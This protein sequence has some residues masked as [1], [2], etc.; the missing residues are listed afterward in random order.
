MLNLPPLLYQGETEQAQSLLSLWN[1]CLSEV[2]IFLLEIVVSD[3]VYVPNK[4]LSVDRVLNA[5]LRNFKNLKK[6][7]KSTSPSSI[8]EIDLN[9]GEDVLIFCE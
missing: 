4:F 2:L 3:G 6:W 8:D 9:L 5:R 7:S 1:S